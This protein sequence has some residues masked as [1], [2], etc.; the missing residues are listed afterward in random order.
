MHLADGYSLS[1]CCAADQPAGGRGDE[2]RLLLKLIGDAHLSKRR[3]FQC[4]AADGFFQLGRDTVFDTGLPPADLLERELSSRLIQLSES[5][6]A[7]SRIAE[8]LARLGYTPEAAAPVEEDLL[9][10]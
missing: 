7:I 3:L 9:C 5:I 1:V 8:D 4:H 10:S 2:Q 6:R